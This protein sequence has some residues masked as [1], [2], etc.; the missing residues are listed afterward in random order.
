MVMDMVRVASYSPGIGSSVPLPG[1]VPERPV[2]LVSFTGDLDRGRDTALVAA[3]AEMNGCDPEPT[4]EELGSGVS[5]VRY[6][7]C[8][9]AVEL[10]DIDGMGHVWPLHDCLEET[11]P[12]EA[13][14]YCSEY[15]EVDYLEDALRFFDENPLP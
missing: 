3:W 13:S 15:E 6:E 14:A 9:A 10:F 11:H 2:P 8:D 4:I 7:G 5:H 12:G 1:C